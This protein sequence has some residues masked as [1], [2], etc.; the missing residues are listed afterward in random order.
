MY[1]NL[2]TLHFFCA[3]AFASANANDSSARTEGI[4]DVSKGLQCWGDDIKNIG[5]VST[6]AECCQ[7]CQAF[8]GCNAWTWN[9]QNGRDC[10]LKSACSDKRNDS[11]YHSGIG[12]PGPSPPSPDN[13]LGIVPLP[14][15]SD[16]FFLIIGD[17]GVPRPSS[18]WPYAAGQ[19]QDKVAQMMKDYVQKFEA[20]GKK[21]LFVG[22]V[23]DNFYSTGLQDD[24]HWAEQWSNV[25]GT[26]DVNSP[27]HDIPWLAVMGNHDLGNADATCA[28]GNGCKQ[29]NGA[30]RP[31]GTESF[32]MPDYY[33]HYY[34]P[35]V[36]VE[37]IGIDTNAIDVGGIGG[38]GCKNGGAVT[39][40]TC[41][42]QNNIQT[43]LSGK[44]SAGENYLDE[45]AR[46]TSA[47]TALIMQ[48]YDGGL[49]AQYKQ[50]FENINGGKAQVLS[51]YG[52]AHDQACQGN[53]TRG[54]DVILTGGGG[55]W[56]GGAYFGFTAV[57][58]TDDGGYETTLESNEVRISQGSCN[59]VGEV[60]RAIGENVSGSGGDIE[61]FV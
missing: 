20:Q 53:R 26:N 35:G 39:C 8:S 3:V 22:A 61:V 16:N 18:N 44:Q 52:H 27:L 2:Q 6:D 31:S 15:R 57:H 45:R 48:H 5:P 11:L 37:V 13:P 58:L 10:Y 1:L 42:G 43:F 59:Y 32:W 51:A 17:W 54:C 9:W 12:A 36:D 49:G 23:G 21:C 46:I 60:E 14:K 4:C 56:R 50:R 55:G 29:F 25:Y 7:A 41:G 19:C 34:I 47:K 30:H 38:D 28:C 40:Q 24:A 33:W